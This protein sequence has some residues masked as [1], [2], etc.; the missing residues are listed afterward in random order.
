[1]CL[2][3]V[4][5]VYMFGSLPTRLPPLRGELVYACVVCVHSELDGVSGDG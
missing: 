4:G 2:D 5:C 3:L 1:M